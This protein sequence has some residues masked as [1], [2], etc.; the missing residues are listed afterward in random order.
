ML[1][2]G[3][4]QAGDGARVLVVDDEPNI[5][6]LIATALRYQGFEVSTAAGGREAISKTQ[7]FRPDLIL[8]DVMLPDFDGFEVQRRLVTDRVK[9]PVIF[10]T[11]R[12]Q[13]ES[14]VHGLTMGADDYIT[15]PFSLE[16]LVA[17]VRAV[18]RRS[19]GRSDTGGSIL[20]FADLELDDDLHEVR[21][22]NTLIDLTPTEFTLLR[23]LL[24]NARRVMS[25]S[26]IL[27]H[28]WQYDFGGDANVVE[29]Y[30]SYLRRKID[31]FEPPL[32]QTIRGVGYS[33]RL[34]RD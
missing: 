10:L 30:I 16:E 11:A 5:T 7:S 17:R 24:M 27:D 2:G 15:K 6:D 26:Q 20:K 3:T 29:T 28:V 4:G 13:T 34:P 18:L 21:R 33:L 8:L 9:T 31:R 32:I 23:Y 19:A 12:D 14:K 25:K 1:V 22:A